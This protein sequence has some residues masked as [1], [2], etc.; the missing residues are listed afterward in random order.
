MYLI[1]FELNISNETVNYQAFGP[2]RREDDLYLRYTLDLL[3]QSEY[4]ILL[5]DAVRPNPKIQD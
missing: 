2:L 3:N 4:R 5:A 1:D